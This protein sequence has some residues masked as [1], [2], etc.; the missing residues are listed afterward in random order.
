[1]SSD[2]HTPSNIGKGRIEDVR[3]RK[4]DKIIADWRAE[5]ERVI[6]ALH[7]E[8]LTPEQIAGRLG[9]PLDL[10]QEI[11]KKLGLFPKPSTP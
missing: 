11:F 4:I 9:L 3:D 6:T 7:E 1:M 8:G 5:L 2:D 10:A